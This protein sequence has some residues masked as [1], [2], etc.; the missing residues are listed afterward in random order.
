LPEEKGEF[1]VNSAYKLLLEEL[2]TEDEV[3]GVL[4]NVLDQI[5]DSLAPSKVIALSC[6]LLFDRI[7]TRSN[8]EARGVVCSDK[9][10][11]CLGCVGKVENSSHLFLHCASAMKIWCEIF[12]WL[13][14][15]IVTP[16]SIAILFEVVRGSA[17]NDRI[18]K[19]FILIWHAT[20]WSIWKARN[21]AIFSVGCFR[22]YVI[23][24]EIKVLSWKWS[25]GRLKISPCLFYEWCWDPG[26][27]LLS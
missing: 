19:G 17:K 3:E 5:W 18:R 16:P 12:S 6:Q 22:P 23:V 13:G 8:L 24:E 25:L 15:V 7:P 4:A 1:S 2:E 21:S 11:E 26:S 20:L 10:W 9:P 14:V 27:C